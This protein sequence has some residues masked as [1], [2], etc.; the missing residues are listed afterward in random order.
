MTKFLTK[1]ITVIMATAT[2]AGC[3]GSGLN[4]EE[5]RVGVHNNNELKIQINVITTQ[6]ADVYAEYWKTGGSDSV[7]FL[8]TVS[9]NV[10]KHKLIL[11]NVIAET[12][13][14]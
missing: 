6:S 1:C 4:I 5:I 13:Y 11:C 7:K 8:S 10:E 3:S 9:H 2:L 14:A 12:N